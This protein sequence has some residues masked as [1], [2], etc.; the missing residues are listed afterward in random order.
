M[1]RNVVVI[2]ARVQTENDC[3]QKKRT[4]AYCRV[5]TNM[6]SQES[7]IANQEE[8]YYNLINKN[9]ELFY[10]GTYIDKGKKGKNTYSRKEF[11]RMI[12]DCKLGRIDQIMTKS[13]SRFARNTLDSLKYIRMLKKLGVNVYFEKE[14]LN[15]NDA[16]SEFVFTVLSSLAEEESRNISTNLK[17]SFKKKFQKGEPMFPYTK[18]IGYNVVNKKIII[19]EKEAKIIR[20]I[21]Y[22]YINGQSTK[23]IAEAMMNK[24]YLTGNKN[25]KWNVNYILSIIH[26]EKY[27]GDLLLGKT[28]NDNLYEKRRYENDGRYDRYYLKNNHE[29]IVSKAV[30]YAAQY[31]EKSRKTIKY[32]RISLA[33]EK[34]CWSG[35]LKDSDGIK[36]GRVIEKRKYYQKAVWMKNGT[37]IDEIELKKILVKALKDVRLNEN[38]M[39]AK[40]IKLIDSEEEKLD[41][42][43]QA[44][45]QY[46]ACVIKKSK[47]VKYYDDD[48]FIT[49][50]KEIIVDK[51]SVT[52]VFRS[53]DKIR[54]S[55]I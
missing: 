44:L 27:M 4:C 5:S 52:I 39:I 29:P 49:L 31:E 26:N 6:E 8:Y 1:N 3:I 35:K 40:D 28:Y 22:R 45:N 50:L 24:G 14:N 53:N 33:N 16:H 30:W 10:A 9:N 12:E 18:F 47:N 55:R 11:L 46:V 23:E 21:F 25:T 32:N 36:L 7:S 15:S 51:K 38:I 2:P 48:I 54:I 37:K 41:F 17:W 34:L 20:E 43:K 19:V 42:G 13:I